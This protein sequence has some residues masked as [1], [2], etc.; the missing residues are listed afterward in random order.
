MNSIKSHKLKGALKKK[1]FTERS[2]TNHAIYYLVHNGKKQPIFTVVSRSINDYGR[3]L[4]STV[5]R[6]MKLTKE[7]FKDFCN[8]PMSQ[9]DYID[10]LKKKGE[11]S[12]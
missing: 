12:E 6:E 4:I 11:L 2:G 10:V 8:C 7:E 5:A 9:Q 1:G 3:Q